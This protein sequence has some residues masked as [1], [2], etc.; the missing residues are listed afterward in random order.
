MPGRPVFNEMMRRVQRG[1][2]QGIICWKLDRLARNPVDGGQVE[3]FLQQ[4]VIQRIA[5]PE[6]SYYSSDNVLVMS[7]ELGM[8]NQYIRDLSTNTKRGQRQK[9]RR[10]EYPGLAPLGY[11]NN[12]RTHRVEIDRR[13]A[14][15]IRAAFEMYAEG[16]SRFE[17]IAALLYERGVRTKKQ[18]KSGYTGDKPLTKDR[19]KN[20]LTNIFYY[21]H[22]TYAGEVYKGTHT[23]IISKQLFD[24]A[25]EVLELR[26]RQRHKLKNQPQPLCGIMR[27][28]ECGGMITAEVITKRQKNGNV[29]RYVY[30]RCTKKRGICSQPYIREEELSIQLSELLSPYTLPTNWADELH[31]LA[32]QDEHEA[33]SLSRIAVF[34]LRQNVVQLDTKLSRFIDLYADQDI[35]RDTF[36]ARKRDIMSE[37][38][39]AEEQIAK[40]EQ[41]AGS[42]LQPLREFINDASMLDGIA[43]SGD[44][45][46]Q[47]SSLQKIFGSNLTLHAR[48]ARGVAKPQYAA[49]RAAK[50]NF[51]VIPTAER[52]RFE[53]SVP[54]GTPVFETGAL[55]HSATSP[56]RQEILPRVLARKTRKQDDVLTCVN[57]S[58]RTGR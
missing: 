26:G 30:Y 49:L 20:I 35:D 14:P 37:K 24:K 17:D 5:T 18:N 38:K 44:F 46:S 53:L 34:E 3:W 58:Q 16:K 55:D 9:A 25:Q 43:A 21:G 36:L 56:W 7:V 45:S 32:D 23:P 40:L 22:F 42:W 51:P 54:F 15:H 50:N 6:R 4:S 52:E 12:P 47:K 29:H 2:V 31:Y 8:A 48:E 39:S 19:I 27:C 28:G 33:V 13:K 11:V 57:T 41:D 1:E 10:G